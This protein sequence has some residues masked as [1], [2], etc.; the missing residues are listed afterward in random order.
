VPDARDLSRRLAERGVDISP[1]GDRRMRAVTHLDVE[2]A[3][4]ESAL[5]AFRAALGA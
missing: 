3:G 2:R 4:I 5:D 1:L